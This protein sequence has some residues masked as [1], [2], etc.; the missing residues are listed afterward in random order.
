MTDN[1]KPSQPNKGADAPH[2]EPVYEPEIQRA[3][4]AEVVAL[5]S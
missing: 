1:S 2:T 4:L 5:V 3:N